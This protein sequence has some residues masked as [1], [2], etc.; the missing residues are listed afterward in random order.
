MKKLTGIFVVTIAILCGMGYLAYMNAPLILAEMLSNK[1]HTPI[2]IRNIDFRKEAFTIEGFL[3]GNPKEARLPVALKAETINVETPYKQY[4]WSPIIINKIHMDNL[5]VNIQIYNKDQ[6][7]GNWQ[8][9]IKNMDEDHKSIFSIE[10]ETVIKKLTLTNIQVNLILSDGKLHKLSP[11]ARLEFD[12]VTTE[13]GI[14]TQEISEIIAQKMI[15]SLFFQ[16]GIKAIIET[17]MKVIKGIFP[18]L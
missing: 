15:E 7:E 18:F 12:N 10:R 16:Q 1:T 11:I 5:Y 13:K 9:I 2:T 4:L 3:I 8:T 17:P 14:P 6:T